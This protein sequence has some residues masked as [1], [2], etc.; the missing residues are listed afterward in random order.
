MTAIRFKIKF[1]TPLLIGGAKQIE[2]GKE[3]ETCDTL[4]LGKALRGGWRFWFRAACGGMLQGPDSAR[5][6]ALHQLESAVFG[7]TNTSTFR[8]LVTREDDVG[9]QKYPRCPH[10]DKGYAAP[11]PGCRPDA[12]FSVT[13]Q[14][15]KCRSDNSHA[16]EALKAAI[17]L[18][19]NL[20]SVGNRA[21]RGF[22][23]P[24]LLDDDKVFK[25]YPHVEQ[26]N[27]E[28]QE[29]LTKHLKD[30]TTAALNN[31]KEYIDSQNDKTSDVTIGPVSGNAD[32]FILGGCGQIMVG[33]KPSE[34]L[35]T[36]DELK[37]KPDSSAKGLM[38][39]IHGCTRN[40]E[41]GMS[42]PRYAS[43]VY[44][45]LHKVKN[46]YYPVATWSRQPVCNYADSCD[47]RVKK[48]CTVL[49]KEAARS[50]TAQH[51]I[52]NDL[53]CKANILGDTL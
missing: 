35:F 36:D 3:K 14:P 51:Y 1:I 50:L 31:I 10:K 47:Y 9:D 32:F 29:S 18:W 23:C 45:R 46:L 25:V 4:S 41:I 6:T 5:I 30:G 28:S 19:A 13:I 53:Q 7:S 11:R 20:G 49:R 44:V 34:I 33:D 12:T 8:M 38:N 16:I 40:N 42:T 21:R 24:S 43:P 48:H 15:R 2:D 26:G 37:L 27:F 22:G 39:I 17:W 52:K